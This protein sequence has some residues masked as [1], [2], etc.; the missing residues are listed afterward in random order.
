MIQFTKERLV[1]M[2]G[3]ILYSMGAVILGFF[4]GMAV[5]HFLDNDEIHA[6]EKKNSALHRENAYLRKA[7]KTEVIEI[8]DK[9]GEVDFS[10]KW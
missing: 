5:K 8:V 1:K 2:L 6:L 10:Q 3:F 7:C 9:R 4:F